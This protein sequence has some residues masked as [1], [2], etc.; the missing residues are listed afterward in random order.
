[1]FTSHEKPFRSPLRAADE[2]FFCS[3]IFVDDDENCGF[4][5][6]PSR[7]QRCSWQ[8]FTLS[9]VFSHG[10]SYQQPKHLAGRLSK[11]DDSAEPVTNIRCCIEKRVTDRCRTDLVGSIRKA[12][13]CQRPA[14][15]RRCLRPRCSVV[16]Q[17]SSENQCTRRTA[18][19]TTTAVLHY[20]ARRLCH[21]ARKSANE[22]TASA[23]LHYVACTRRRTIRVH[24]HARCGAPWSLMK[25]CL[26]QPL[27][28]TYPVPYES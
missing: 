23:V 15:V 27:R 4:V 6:V 9:R 1:M 10:G 3:F 26:A 18:T 20:V 25:N 2:L 8:P 12:C 7:K 28:Q 5:L 11:T 13:R 16:Q 21:R 14:I 22:A 17:S 24:T 19:T